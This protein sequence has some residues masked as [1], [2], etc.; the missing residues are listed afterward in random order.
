[1]NIEIQYYLMHILLLTATAIAGYKIQTSSTSRYW[2]VASICI[3]TFLLVEGLRW[4]RQ[5]DWILYYDV[6]EQIKSGIDTEH[7]FLFMLLWQFFAF[8]DIPYPVVVCFSSFLLITSLLTILKDYKP[9]YFFALLYLVCI[10]CHVSANLQRWFLGASFLYWALC[11]FQKRMYRVAIVI[12]ICACLFHVAIIIVL[13]LFFF[14]LK[15]DKVLMKPLPATLVLVLLTVFFDPSVLSNFTIIFDLFSNV[16][17]FAQYMEDPEGWLNGTASTVEMEKRSLLHNLGAIVPYIFAIIANY[18]ILINNSKSKNYKN[19]GLLKGNNAF[20]YNTFVLGTWVLAITM[21]L[22]L[23]GR[24]SYLFYPFISIALANAV[25]YYYRHKTILYKIGF[26]ACFGFLLLKISYN[27]KPLVD[28]PVFM[29][30]VWDSNQYPI[31]IVR[32]EMYSSKSK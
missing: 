14:L 5:I 13:P 12:S 25:K 17:R 32:S 23:V 16:S 31:N 24:Y 30:Y 22:E 8:L 7:E 10:I 3:V 4:G 9:V 2:Q 6:Y 26:L 27:I 15:Y 21:S 11:Y 18:H 20:I 19:Y 29:G 28:N 1:M